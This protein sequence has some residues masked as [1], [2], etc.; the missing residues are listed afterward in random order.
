M[1][2]R[3]LWRSLGVAIVCLLVGACNPAEPDAV[4]PEP[5]TGGAQPDHIELPLPPLSD[6]A[7]AEGR[8][9]M[10]EACPKILSTMDG[11]ETTGGSLLGLCKCAAFMDDQTTWDERRCD[12]A[13]NI[14]GKTAA[15]AKGTLGI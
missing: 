13:L 4:A 14:P 1:A 12:E 11:V 6:E 10:A 5:S 8:A 7:L 15:D 3:Q 9:L 2:G